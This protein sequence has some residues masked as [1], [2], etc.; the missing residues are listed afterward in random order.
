MQIIHLVEWYSSS[1]VW[2][3]FQP[4]GV[5]TVPNICH[6]MVFVC[7]AMEGR[8]S[9]SLLC[10]THSSSHCVTH[11][12]SPSSMRSSLDWMGEASMTSEE[13]QHQTVLFLYSLL[14]PVL[15]HF[16]ALLQSWRHQTCKQKSR[17]V[18]TGGGVDN[19]III[20]TILLL[21]QVWTLLGSYSPEPPFWFI[22]IFLVV[23]F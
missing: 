5:F 2:G 1:I 15:S 4:P 18:Q 13:S 21:E 23:A 22:Q 10:I 14:S 7:V 8:E 6:C 17:T 20:D 19:S 11:S 9:S 3:S 16:Y 12:S